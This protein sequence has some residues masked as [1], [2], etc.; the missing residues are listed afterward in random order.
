MSKNFEVEYPQLAITVCEWSYEKLLWISLG[1]NETYFMKGA[2]T[3]EAY[4]PLTMQSEIRGVIGGITAFALGIDET[5]VIVH[6]NQWSWNLKGHYSGLD[7]RLEKAMSA[8]RVCAPA[9]SGPGTLNH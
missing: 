5:Y 1:P 8:P 2:D 4:L 6:G 9:L 7:I 3:Y